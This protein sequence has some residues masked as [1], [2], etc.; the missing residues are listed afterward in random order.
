MRQDQDR[1]SRPNHDLP[2]ASSLRELNE[3]YTAAL[4]KWI[5]RCMSDSNV[6]RGV[7]TNVDKNRITDEL[8]RINIVKTGDRS[9]D[10]VSAVLLMKATVYTAVDRAVNGR[11]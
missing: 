6:G 2:N 11:Y 8:L 3:K 4:A 10:P 7:I 9:I 1:G 5:A